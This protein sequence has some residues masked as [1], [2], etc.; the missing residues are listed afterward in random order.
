MKLSEHQLEAL[1]TL[2]TQMIPTNSADHKKISLTAL[3]NKELAVQVTYVSGTFFAI[4]ES[5]RAFLNNQI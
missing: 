1:K 3:E 4:S 2:R 5:G